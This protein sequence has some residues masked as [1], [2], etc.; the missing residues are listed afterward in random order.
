MSRFPDLERGDRDWIESSLTL[1]GATVAALVPKGFAA[2]ARVHH[3]AQAPDARPGLTI[4]EYAATH[5]RQLRSRSDAFAEADRGVHG[6]RVRSGS[7]DEWSIGGLVDAIR[8]LGGSSDRCTFAVWTGWAG[9]RRNQASS[10]ILE[11]PGRSYSLFAAPLSSA[12][13]SWV[14]A[15]LIFQSA[16]LWWP[17]ARSWFVSTEVDLPWTYVAGPRK[18]L[19]FIAADPR[20]D[21]EEV[22]WDDEW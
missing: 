1:V 21:A 2:Y 6:F 15:P 18:L 5:G 19:H 22:S 4:R 14:D 7:L 20:V 9:A 11:L 10:A 16:N 12:L 17:D 13:T 8:R 3:R